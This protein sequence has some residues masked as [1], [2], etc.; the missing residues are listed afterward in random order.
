MIIIYYLEYDEFV[1]GRINL[2]SVKADS[3]SMNTTIKNNTE[4]V[5]SVY[6]SLHLKHFYHL[7]LKKQE[8][9]SNDNIEEIKK[10]RLKKLKRI[11]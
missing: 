9:G 7:K 2:K 8:G 1:A 10:K 6:E 3:G 11:L 4:G 5:K